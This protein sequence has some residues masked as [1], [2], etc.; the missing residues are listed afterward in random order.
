MVDEPRHGKE[1]ISTANITVDCKHPELKCLA[2][3][4]SRNPLYSFF[5][6][7]MDP[8]GPELCVIESVLGD[9]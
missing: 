6:W 2:T 1:F 5:R 7:I 3:M 9:H 8:L 4:R